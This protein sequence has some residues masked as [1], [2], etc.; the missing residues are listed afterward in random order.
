VTATPPAG[1]QVGTPPAAFKPAV[2][3]DPTSLTFTA[4]AQENLTALSCELEGGAEGIRSLD[5]D[6][7]VNVTFVNNT[8]QSVSVFWLD[9]EGRRHYPSPTY[10]YGLDLPYNTLGPGTSYVQGTYVTHPWVLVGADETC[11]GIFLPNSNGG[12]VTVE[13]TSY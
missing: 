5:S 2:V 4:E 3:F 6:A 11:Y 9:Y 7:P 12:I 8:S 13:D 10:A 1:T